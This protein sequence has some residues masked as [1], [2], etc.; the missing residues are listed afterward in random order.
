[1][2]TTPSPPVPAPHS[3][4]S[5]H[6]SPSH[7]LPVCTCPR[8]PRRARAAIG[9]RRTPAGLGVLLPAARCPLPR[10]APRRAFG[11]ASPPSGPR[12]REACVRASMCAPRARGRGASVTVSEHAGFAQA[13]ART[14]ARL[15]AR[16]R[17]TALLPAPA[18]Q[19]LGQASGWGGSWAVG[20]SGGWRGRG[21]GACGRM[22]SAWEKRGGAS[23]RGR[24]RADGRTGRRTGARARAPRPLRY[25]DLA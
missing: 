20:R 15:H 19:S 7:V 23:R 24:G 16:T 10:R 17:S 4:L 9:P 14:H 12:G 6:P 13:R 25:L 22:A 1:M 18:S 5:M 2:Q 8:R 11:A 3:A 21:R